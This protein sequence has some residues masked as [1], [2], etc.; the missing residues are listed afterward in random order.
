MP[1]APLVPS[2]A[3]AAEDWPDANDD[4]CGSPRPFTARTVCHYGS[5]PVKVALVGN[6]HVT[7]WLPALQIIAAQ[8]GWTIDTYLTSE[9]N[10]GGARLG[11]ASPS[12]RDRCQAYSAWAV[13]AVA[14]GGYSLIITS[15][16]QSLP[17]DGQSWTTTMAPAQRAYAST[18]RAWAKGGAS[19][20]VIQDPVP[21]SLEVGRVPECL[22]RS[23]G[24]IAPCSWPAAPAEPD[25]PTVYRWMDP[26]AAAAAAL[27]LAKVGAVSMDRYLCSP[28]TC[29][30]VIGTVITYRD[31]SHLTATYTRTLAPYL[32][33]AITGV[34]GP[35]RS[36]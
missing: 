9:C 23:G 16:R 3:L 15:E 1:D 20:V 24:A 7:Q 12:L 11:F 18:L 27:K 17:V 4:N 22:S 6:S 30:P 14:R 31:A 34:T 10:V 28:E 5:G 13:R 36:P 32:D 33:A 8:R 19:V 21:P 29:W 26:L 2:P 25:D 35:S